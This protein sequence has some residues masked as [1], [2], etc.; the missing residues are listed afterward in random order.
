[1]TYYEF[2]MNFIRI[3]RNSMSYGGEVMS[4][5][6]SVLQKDSKRGPRGPPGEASCEE[7]ATNY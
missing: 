5:S 3:I 4:E 6:G 1:M 7:L 2:T